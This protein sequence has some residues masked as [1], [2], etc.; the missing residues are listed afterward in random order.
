MLHVYLWITSS[1]RSMQI[2]NKVGFGEHSMDLL[3]L[4][5]DDQFDE[6]DA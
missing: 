4:Y 1:F 6:I 5:L 3:V 2:G